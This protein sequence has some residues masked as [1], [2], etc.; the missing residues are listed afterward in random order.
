MSILQLPD[1][2]LHAV[3]SHS[4]VRDAARLSETCRQFGGAYRSCSAVQ[5]YK[6]AVTG[7]G[8]VNVEPVALQPAAAA[9]S[10]VLADADPAGPASTP[11]PP[12]RQTLGSKV[13]ALRAQETAW[14][15]LTPHKFQRFDMPGNRAEEHDFSSGLV[16]IHRH[17]GVSDNMS[18]AEEEADSLEGFHRNWISVDFGRVDQRLANDFGD[19]DDF[20]FTRRLLYRS[21]TCIAGIDAQADLLLLTE[22]LWHSD[23]TCTTRFHILSLSTGQG[24]PRAQHPVIMLK[25]DA[26]ETYTTSVMGPARDTWKGGSY[27]VAVRGNLV[28][29]LVFKYS[30]TERG[31]LR[32]TFIVVFDWTTG[33]VAL[34][35]VFCEVTTDGRQTISLPETHDSPSFTFLADDLIAVAPLRAV[36][37]PAHVPHDPRLALEV[38]TIPPRDEWADLLPPKDIVETLAEEMSDDDS[39]TDDENDS[40]SG[41]LDDDDEVD[42]GSD[43]EWESLDS[44]DDAAVDA[45]IDEL[46]ALDGAPSTTADANGTF[47]AET[48][49]PGTPH[50]DPFPDMASEVYSDPEIEIENWADSDSESPSEGL[51][52]PPILDTGDFLKL[53]LGPGDPEPSVRFLLPPIADDQRMTQAVILGHGPISPPSAASPSPYAVPRNFD[54][55]ADTGVL[56]LGFQVTGADG[57]PKDYTLFMRQEKLASL[58]RS[59]ASQATAPTEVRWADWGEE[60]TR[61][62][63]EALFARETADNEGCKNYWEADYE[64]RAHGYRFA[65]LRGFGHEGSSAYTAADNGVF[66]LEVY[67]FAP[68]AEVPRFDPVD[69]R[70]LEGGS[71][72]LRSD[73]TVLD[74]FAVPVVTRLPFL[75]TRRRLAPEL[76][77]DSKAER[78]GYG[79]LLDAQRVALF[80]LQDVG[81]V[82]GSEVQELLVWT[83]GRGEEVRGDEVAIAQSTIAA[84]RLAPSW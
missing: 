29:T 45:V 72:V 83:F 13:A 15:T 42:N 17:A 50:D 22:D 57:P 68:G 69:E 49:P 33:Q 16:V 61:I 58:A 73:A 41:S 60:N 64:A 56:V 19:E 78:L 37:R 10:D 35:S 30:D 39:M 2:L 54:T 1:E 55:D 48:A 12:E 53:I 77:L 43:N 27:C 80:R 51:P 76:R 6:A 18:E 75:A 38:Y 23:S 34:V 74:G 66:D 36:P 20:P 46:A 82:A 84:P 21:W 62:L 31:V 26:R 52:K 67:D 81:E 14:R 65:A 28:A 11:P 25:V 47:A 3:F 71:A 79:L 5:W 7:G 59:H 8:Y 44:D 70:G 32:G 4:S 40:G 24:H 9:E 63:P